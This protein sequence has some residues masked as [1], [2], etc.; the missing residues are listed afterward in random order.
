MMFDPP[1][2]DPVSTYWTESFQPGDNELAGVGNSAAQRDSGSYSELATREG[3]IGYVAA[4]R[5]LKKARRPKL[6]TTK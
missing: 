5:T 3:W 1:A 4:R 6:L 2:S